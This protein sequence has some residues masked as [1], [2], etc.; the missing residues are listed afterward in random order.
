[1]AEVY[2]GKMEKNFDIT[3]YIEA[4]KKAKKE[5]VGIWSLSNYQSPKEFRTTHKN[6]N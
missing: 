3:P 2:K 5:K 1:M 6:N 4:E